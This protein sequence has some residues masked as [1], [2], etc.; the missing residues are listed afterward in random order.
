MQYLEKFDLERRLAVE[1]DLEKQWDVNES[2]VPS[3]GFDES[4]TYLYYGSPVGIK[5][6]SL[7]TGL[8]ERLVGKVESTE[9]F[10]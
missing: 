3:I 9:R 6:V 8:V 7:R 1:R 10:L 2:T 4:G 5:I